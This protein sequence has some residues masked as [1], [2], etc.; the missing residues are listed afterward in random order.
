[1]KPKAREP[2]K[3]K[4]T[5]DSP[6]RFTPVPTDFTLLSRWIRPAHPKH[7]LSPRLRPL[8]GVAQV[9]R[10]PGCGPGGRRFKSGRSPSI[11]GGWTRPKRVVR[12]ELT[13]MWHLAILHAFAARG[14]FAPP[15]RFVSSS[16]LTTEVR[17]VLAGPS[18]AGVTS[19]RVAHLRVCM[20]SKR[21]N[22]T[23]GSLENQKFD[24]S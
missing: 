24:Q 21:K 3:A 4:I 13:G 5:S 20:G 18:S 2:A 12:R 22:R 14:A 11:S 9:V 19:C 6:P 8:V 17:V 7:G 16:C 1:M 15:L 23:A 10:A